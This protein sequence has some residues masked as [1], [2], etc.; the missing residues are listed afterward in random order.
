CGSA[1][2]HPPQP[3][4]LV[5]VKVVSEEG[6]VLASAV[7]LAATRVSRL[8]ELA[9]AS[10]SDPSP[11]DCARFPA[12]AASCWTKVTEETQKLFIAVYAY[13]A[14]TTTSISASLI[15]EREL[16][17]QV[18]NSGR[19]RPGEG[20]LPQPE[21]SLLSVPIALLPAGLLTVS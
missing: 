17:L 1:F 4:H 10:G 14:C 9:W 11:L 6:P 21:L 7:L 12:L 18:T 8:K 16:Q 3:A 20:T 13:V 5:P 15:S 19:C 2:S